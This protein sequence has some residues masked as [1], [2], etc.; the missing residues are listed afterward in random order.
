FMDTIR[1]L[2]L[3]PLLGGPAYLAFASLL[4]GCSIG[5]PFSSDIILITGGVLAG[6]GIFELKKTILL[7]F[8][9]ILTGD[10]I[11]FFV[12]RKYGRSIVE[13]PFFRRFCPPERF[14]EISRFLTQSASKFIFSVRFTPGMRSVIFLT[15]GVVGVPAETFLKMNSLS[16]SLYVSALIS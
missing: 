7:A 1:A 9:A 6:T 12:G 11:A 14:E 13:R 16:T 2:I 10:S 3:S 15:A 8:V 4:T 5:L